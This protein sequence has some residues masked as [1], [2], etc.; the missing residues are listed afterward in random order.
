MFLPL[1]ISILLAFI[2]YPLGP[3]V[4]ITSFNII[5]NETFL[6]VSSF[7]HT[8]KMINVVFNVPS[9]KVYGIYI[10]GQTRQLNLMIY[11]NLLKFSISFIFSLAWKATPLFPRRRKLSTT[12][13]V[14]N[15]KVNAFVLLLSHISVSSA[16]CISPGA[17]NCSILSAWN[18][19]FSH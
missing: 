12:K 17:W 5:G 19:K 18:R 15:V 8:T 13:V 3:Q 11:N 1:H 4:W 16:R 6:F 7:E 2:I 10:T 9:G 14:S